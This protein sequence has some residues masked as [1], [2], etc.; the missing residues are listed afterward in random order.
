MDDLYVK[1]EYRGLGLGTKL[2]NEVISFARSQNC[3]KVRWQVSEWNT[4]SIEF[5]KSLG[6]KL[7]NLE[8]RCDLIL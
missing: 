8:Y 4:N 1:P 5:Y 7:D 3:H 6:A 2:I